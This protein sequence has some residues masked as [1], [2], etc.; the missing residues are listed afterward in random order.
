MATEQWQARC[1][2]VLQIVPPV[3]QVCKVMAYYY[4]MYIMWCI[5]RY[6]SWNNFTEGFVMYNKSVQMLL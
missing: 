2:C 5:C 6:L 4:I 1:A 3:F